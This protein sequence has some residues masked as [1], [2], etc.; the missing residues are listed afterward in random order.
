[1]DRRCDSG[2]QAQGVTGSADTDIHPPLR[3][4]CEWH[5]QSGTGSTI[6]NTV[7]HIAHYAHNRNPRTSRFGRPEFDVFSYRPRFTGKPSTHEKLANQRPQG[8]Y[9][10]RRY[11]SGAGPSEEGYATS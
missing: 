9:R 8:E 11:R 1:M 6:P 4:L 2:N 7:H 5:V 10:L 3:G